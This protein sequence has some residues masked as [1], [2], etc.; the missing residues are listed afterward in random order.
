MTRLAKALI[1]C[2]GKGTRMSSLTKGAAKELLPIAGVPLVLRVMEECAASGVREVLI[3]SAPGK[4][5]L[6]ETVLA[7]AGRPRMPERVQVVTQENPRGLADAIRLG[8]DFAK[9][10]TLGVAL[11]DNLFLSDEP[12]LAQLFR[13]HEQTGKNVVAI[14]ELT[15]VNRDR[16]GPTAI[17]PGRLKGDE[18]IIESIPGKG[19]RQDT[20]DLKGAASAFT[21]VGRYVFLPEV[22]LAIDEVEAT[23]PSGQELDDIP[24]MQLLLRRDRLTGCRIR[25]DFLDVG[26]P[27]GYREADERLARKIP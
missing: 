5:D 12:A 20:F 6:S 13:I 8:R 24:V 18:Y 1:P 9:N 25:G 14:V 26:L 10:D 23:L 19:P 16:Y 4:E 27:T 17:Y 22:F 11:P 7:A 2:G 21:G 15:A 3:V